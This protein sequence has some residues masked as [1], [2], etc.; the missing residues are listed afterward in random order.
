MQLI[1]L[2]KAHLGAFYNTI[3]LH[4][5]ATCLYISFI[6][7]FKSHLDETL[8]RGPCL[9]ITFLCWWDVKPS[10]L[11]HSLIYLS[12]HQPTLGLS[13]H[14]YHFAAQSPT[15]IINNE[16]NDGIVNSQYLKSLDAGHWLD[17][18]YI[19][20]QGPTADSGCLFAFT[21]VWMRHNWS[22]YRSSMYC[23]S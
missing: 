19:L 7:L 12:N 21:R 22:N 8:N 1:V 13:W 23:H 14:Y 18:S 2:Q 20:L 11:T 17:L 16:Q 9:R 15:G 6:H 10:S 3:V 4:L 5:A